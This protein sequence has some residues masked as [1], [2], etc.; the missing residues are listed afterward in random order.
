[1]VG[2]AL[3]SVIEEPYV[4]NIGDF[5]V[6]TI[7]EWLEVLCGFNELRQPDHSGEIGLSSSDVGTGEFDL[8]SVG[9]SVGL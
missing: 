6:W 2:T 4:S 1:M 9:L 3:V 8:V 5:V 7:E